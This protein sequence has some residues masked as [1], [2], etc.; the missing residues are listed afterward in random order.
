MASVSKL[1][2]VAFVL[3]S[4]KAPD[5]FANKGTT[6]KDAIERFENRK[7]KTPSASNNKN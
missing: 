7:L 5:F 1:G 4:K 2:K 6:S 3:D